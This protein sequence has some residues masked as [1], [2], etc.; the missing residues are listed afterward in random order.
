MCKNPLIVV[1]GCVEDV[2]VDGVGEDGVEWGWV[3]EG[4]WVMLLVK[5]VER[6]ES[7]C[8]CGECW[9]RLGC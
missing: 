4:W 1:R 7:G 3:C 2:G 6:G 9:G 5:W 8:L